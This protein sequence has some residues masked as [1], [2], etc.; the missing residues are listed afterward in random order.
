MKIKLVTRN[1]LQI[2][3]SESKLRK[4]Q[5]FAADFIRSKHLKRSKRTDHCDSTYMGVTKALANIAKAS[6]DA[7]FS[8]ENKNIDIVT[9]RQ[10]FGREICLRLVENRIKTKSRLGSRSA[11]K[12]AVYEFETLYLLYTQLSDNSL[13]FTDFLDDIKHGE[14]P[15]NPLACL[16]IFPECS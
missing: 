11:F 13:Q 15:Q 16:D 14:E 6:M 5:E 1:D 7:K 2:F 10:C 4:R 9:Q 3:F 12:K 8:I